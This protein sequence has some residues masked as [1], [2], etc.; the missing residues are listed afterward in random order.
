MLDD[1]F[2]F[3]FKQSHHFQRGH[4]FKKKDLQGGGPLHPK[5]RLPPY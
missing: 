4:Y 5:C 3:Q 1:D 2:T